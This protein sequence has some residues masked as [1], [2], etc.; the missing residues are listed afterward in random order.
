MARQLGHREHADEVKQ[1]LERVPP[2]SRQVASTRSFFH[3][4]PTL[5]G[6]RRQGRYW[7]DPIQRRSRGLPVVCFL[8]ALGTH[9]WVR[10]WRVGR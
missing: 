4:S 7:Q 6:R 1:E 9:G 10:D 5:R 8:C 3:D 2:R